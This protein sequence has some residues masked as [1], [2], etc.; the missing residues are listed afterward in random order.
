MSVGEANQMLAS[1]GVGPYSASLWNNQVDAGDGT[2]RMMKSISFRKGYYSKK[3]KTVKH[4]SVSID[5]AELGSVIRLLQQMHEEVI[6][7]RGMKQ[8]AEAQPLESV[9]GVP[10]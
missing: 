8:V 1:L 6:E 4:Q 2:Q 9:D 5:P 7:R 10:F 3:E